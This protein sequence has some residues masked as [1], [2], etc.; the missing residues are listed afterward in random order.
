MVY[1]D[2]PNEIEGINDDPDLLGKVISENEV[3]RNFINCIFIFLMQ[4]VLIIYCNGG[5]QDEEQ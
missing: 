4:L 2:D 3:S 1:L 5:L